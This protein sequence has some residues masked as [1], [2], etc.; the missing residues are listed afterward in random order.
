[1]RLWT[2][3]PRYLDPRGLVALW[4]EGLLARAVLCGRTVGYRHHPQLVRFASHSSPLHAIDT[5][6]AMVL[7][8]ASA[9]GHS[10]DAAKLDTGRTAVQIVVTDG[11]LTHEWSHL[12]AKLSARSPAL[13]ERWRA[14]NAPEPHPL[15]RIVP[16]PVEPWERAGER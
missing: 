4:R 10:F 9:R 13:H 3:H 15:F 7:E 8:D 12:L 6:L 1:M 2:L 5:Y 14:V 16:G 11:Q